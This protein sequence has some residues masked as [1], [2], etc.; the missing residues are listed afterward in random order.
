MVDNVMVA[1]T[2]ILCTYMQ[3][4]NGC[5]QFKTFFIKDVIH[6]PLQYFLDN[7]SLALAQKKNK[8][9]KNK[10]VYMKHKEL[11]AFINFFSPRELAIL[12]FK[13]ISF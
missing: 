9:N 3:F 13:M 4:T 11:R 6:F 8:N 12:M 5:K 1:Y 7:Y 10:F 2:Y